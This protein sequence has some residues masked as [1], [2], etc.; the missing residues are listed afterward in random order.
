MAGSYSD[1]TK[2][3]SNCRQTERQTERLT[4]A[5]AVTSTT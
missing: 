2:E 4:K 1:R 3:L 5:A